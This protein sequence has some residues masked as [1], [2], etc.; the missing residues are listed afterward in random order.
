M[1][2]IDVEEHVDIETLI[3]ELHRMFNGIE[4][5]IER[6]DDSV[7]KDYDVDSNFKVINVN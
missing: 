2:V 1:I 3:V 4:C 6:V 7:L 5:E